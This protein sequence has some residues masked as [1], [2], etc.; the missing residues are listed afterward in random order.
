MRLV[1]LGN[2]VEIY[3][4]SVH[5]F[6]S[7]AVLLAHFS[8]PRPGERVCD[9]GTGCG[10]LPFLWCRGVADAITPPI[11]AVE[12]QPDAADLAQ[13]SVAHN[14]LEERI[15][16]ISGDLRNP[17][18]LPAGQYD[19]VTCNPPYFASGSGR[20][21]DSPARRIARYEGEQCTLD[22][23][24]TAAARLL[25]HGGRFCLCHRSERLCDVVGALRAAGLEPKR[26]QFVQQKAE[27]APWLLLCEARKGGKPGLDVLPP[28]IL[29]DA[30]TQTALYGSFAPCE[31]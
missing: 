14:R 10:I 2:N 18:L 19:R 22:E 13:R 12:L 27:N 16:I 6:G 31:R 17:A 28:C 11:D 1:S 3:T 20:E 21:S 7:D 8:A 15:R 9:L 30:A 5:T 24:T 26:L 29:E 23:V 4:T 25:R